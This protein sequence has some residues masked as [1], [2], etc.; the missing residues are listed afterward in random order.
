MSPI[1]SNWALSFFWIN[2]SVA[3]VVFI[4]IATNQISS[5]RDLARVLAYGL[6]Y[7]N[8]TGGL[9]VLLVG[10]ILGRFTPRKFP[11]IPVV[12]T[13]VMVITPL[14]C[15]L[16]QTLLME[17]GFVVPEHFWTEYIRTLRVATPLAVVFGSG[18]L[19]H[20]LL[21][22]RLQQMEGR[23]HE[24]EV[25][26]ERA[27]KLAAEA[28]LR[29]L[30]SRI[31][32]HF[33][34][35]AL[36]SISSLIAVNPA[37]AEQIVGRLAALL[38]A[39]LDTGNRPLIPLREE[40]AIV[41]SYMDIEKARFGDKL[42]GTVN[43]PVELEDAQVPPMSVQSLV[44]NAV[45][46]GITPRSGGGE[47]LVTVSAQDSSLRI[48]VRDTGSGFDLATIRAGHGLDNLVERLDALFG[49]RARL[50]VL[51]RDGYSVVEMVLPR[52]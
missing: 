46:H 42:R 36:N 35:N 47:L 16:A 9:G 48:E 44:E 26:E 28:Q 40:L 20:A 43:V 50:N 15:L 45:K 41:E 30:E 23:L 39:S 10:G 13:C 49:P 51:R 27:R 38:R 37:R 14:G 11:L 8:L 21:R 4:Q 6:V 31:H 2:L 52:T 17:I 25:T 29:S 19:V 33:L 1:K 24:K 18:A 7:A 3:I 34:F 12:A 22:T 5:A 32:P